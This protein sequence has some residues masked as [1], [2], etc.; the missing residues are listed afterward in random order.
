MLQSLLK[1]YICI[2]KHWSIL[3]FNLQTSTRKFFFGGR[4]GILDP[5]NS[6][7]ILDPANRADNEKNLTSVFIIFFLSTDWRTWDHKLKISTWIKLKLLLKT[8]ILDGKFNYFLKVFSLSLQ[9]YP[10]WLLAF[11]RTQLP[12]KCNV[13]LHKMSRFDAIWIKIIWPKFAVWN[14]KIDYCHRR[15]PRLN[16][17]VFVEE[18][19]VVKVAEL[20]Y[21][22]SCLSYIGLINA[23]NQL[24]W[25]NLYLTPN[26]GL[27]IAERKTVFKRS[28][29]INLG[30]WLVEIHFAPIYINKNVTSLTPQSKQV[31][32]RHKKYIHIWFLWIC[33]LPPFRFTKNVEAG[34]D[35]DACHKSQ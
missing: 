17:P 24:I 3:F 4:R 16:K 10:L 31:W 11:Y 15:N 20:S 30:F 33:L 26:D 5:A 27:Q 8:R 29:C 14:F 6:R 13:C 2:G 28:R 7:G 22:L 25:I 34:R 12:D 23:A 19:M 18:K 1:M 35:L 9:P 21:V 32:R